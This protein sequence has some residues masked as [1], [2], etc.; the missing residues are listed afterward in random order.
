MQGDV[1]QR[2]QEQAAVQVEIPPPG[3]PIRVVVQVLAPEGD[4]AI[5]VEP[6]ELEVACLRAEVEAGRWGAGAALAS[7]SLA[8]AELLAALPQVRARLRA[9]SPQR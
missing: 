3:G 4:L 7:L 2:G 9:Q 1:E 6:D 5:P 8:C